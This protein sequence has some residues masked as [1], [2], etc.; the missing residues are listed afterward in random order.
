M[1]PRKEPVPFAAVDAK[2]SR[3]FESDSTRAANSADDTP[4]VTVGGGAVAL[5]DSDPK[6]EAQRM[7]AGTWRG[8]KGDIYVINS[9]DWKVARSTKDGRPRTFH[10]NW[11]SDRRVVCWGRTFYAHVGAERKEIEWYRMRDVHRRHR[12]FKWER[13]ESSAPTASVAPTSFTQTRSALLGFRFAAELEPQREGVRLVADYLDSQEK[14]DWE[15]IDAKAMEVKGAKMVERPNMCRIGRPDSTPFPRMWSVGSASEHEDSALS[16][17]D[18]L[19]AALTESPTDTGLTSSDKDGETPTVIGALLGR[20]GSMPSTDH[21]LPCCELRDVTTVVLHN[22][23]RA[24][25]LNQLRDLLDKNGFNGCFDVLHLVPGDDGDSACAFLNFRTPTA[26]HHFVQEFHCTEVAQ[27]VPDVDT[28]ERFVVTYSIAQGYDVLVCSL[29]HPTVVQEL[30]GRPQHQPFILDADGQRVPYP[31]EWTHTDQYPMLVGGDY[32]WTGSADPMS[33]TWSCTTWDPFLAMWEGVAWDGQMWD[34]E[35]WE[36]PAYG[37]SDTVAVH[38]DWALQVDIPKICAGEETRTTI[39]V[40][41][42]AT[43]CTRHRFAEFL[44][45]CGLQERY[46]FLYVGADK[47][48]STPSSIAI[49]NFDAPNDVLQFCSAMAAGLWYGRLSKHPTMPPVTYARFQR[50]EKHDEAR[51][52]LLTKVALSVQQGSDA[53]VE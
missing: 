32:G 13:D 1:G 46:H 6:V 11:N 21:Q 44:A 27:K 3:P 45:A 22:V 15:S 8:D 41:S 20:P 31:P 35:L 34:T 38:D 26:C 39:M 19:L 48:A 12:Q 33:A 4:R 36:L 2:R 28:S 29:C 10:I 17:V 24:Y 51:Q 53:A 5:G 43:T 50:R 30:V 7:F 14:P 9:G 37:A 18:T 23:P 25:Q 42:I 40:R 49:I 52:P 47:Y 16:Q